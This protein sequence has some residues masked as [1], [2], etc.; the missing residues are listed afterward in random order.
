M[1]SGLEKY[2]NFTLPV[3]QVTLKFCLPGA[4]PLLPKFSNSLIIHEP[5]NRSETNVTNPLL[6]VVLLVLITFMFTPFYCNNSTTFNFFIP[7]FMEIFVTT[8]IGKVR[9]ASPN[10][11]MVSD[12]CRLQT[13]DCR[14]QTTD[15][16][17]Q[18]TDYRLQTEDLRP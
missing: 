4:I 10:V 9:E 3:G 11:F 12:I 5:E 16:R 18:T 13:A 1:Y 6:T 8:S 17:L 7:L 14:L 15:C 2:L